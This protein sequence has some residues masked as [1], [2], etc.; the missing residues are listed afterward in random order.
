MLKGTTMKSIKIILVSS[1][2]LTTYSLFPMFAKTITRN[3]SKIA[4][5]QQGKSTIAKFVMGG[6]TAA[7]FSYACYTAHKNN[8]EADATISAM[9]TDLEKI[10]DT[11]KDLVAKVTKQEATK[12]D[13]KK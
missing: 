1:C 9:Q 8:Y 11:S 3:S 12:P 13:S 10:S 7:A 6:S 4:S 5:S 2:L